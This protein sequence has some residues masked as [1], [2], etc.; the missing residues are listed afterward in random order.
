[1]QDDLKCPSMIQFSVKASK[2]VLTKFSLADI[3]H[4]HKTF[5]SIF[6][7]VLSIFLA[8]Y[9]YLSVYLPIYATLSTFI[10]W[11]IETTLSTTAKVIDLGTFTKMK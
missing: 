2:V 4:L 8:V 9:F 11:L 7:S 10:D 5:L 6:L 1:M 3:E